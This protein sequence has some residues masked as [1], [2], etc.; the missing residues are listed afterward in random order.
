[1]SSIDISRRHDLGMERA[2]AIIER[3]AAAVSRKFS[4]DCVWEGNTL[5]IRRNGVDG[6]IDVSADS[7]RVHVQLGMMASMFKGTIEDEIRH[8]LDEHLA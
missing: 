4:V 8:Q 2:R 3:V 7:V 6:R 1:M 5:R